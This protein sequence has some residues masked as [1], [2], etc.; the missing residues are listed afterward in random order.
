[1]VMLAMF[2]RASR[3]SFPSAR[4]GWGGKRRRGE[5]DEGE[6]VGGEHFEREGEAAVGECQGTGCE[7]ATSVRRASVSV[8]LERYRHYTSDYGTW[9]NCRKIW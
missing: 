8:D 5:E 4:P 3:E 9:R 6:E 7:R 1:V 2:R